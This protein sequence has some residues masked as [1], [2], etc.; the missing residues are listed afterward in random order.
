MFKGKELELKMNVIES[1]VGRLQDSE[2]KV[3]TA[4][5]LA[6]ASVALLIN[7]KKLVEF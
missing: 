7:G 3:R 6:L 2:I 1:V 5:V 4:A